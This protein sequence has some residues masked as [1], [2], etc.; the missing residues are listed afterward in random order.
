MATD[1]GKCLRTS[2]DVSPGH[3]RKYPRSMASH[4]VATTGLNAA[5]CSQV[6]SCCFVCFVYALF[7][8]CV[9]LSCVVVGACELGVNGMSHNP[10]VLFLCPMLFA[11]AYL[12]LFSFASKTSV[13]VSTTSKPA[14]QNCPRERS[15]CLSVGST[16]AVVA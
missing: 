11:F 6:T 5:A 8:M 15:G 10:V 3:V 12:T 7:A 1:L 9:L 16:D 14:S 2:A 4:H 13:E